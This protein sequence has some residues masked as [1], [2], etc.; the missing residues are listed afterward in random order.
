[1]V[2]VFFLYLISLLFLSYYILFSSFFIISLFSFILTIFAFIQFL[3]DS[4]NSYQ[5]PKE[6]PV[7]CTPTPSPLPPIEEEEF[8]EVDDINCG[9][10][11]LRMIGISCSPPLTRRRSMNRTSSIGDLLS[12]SVTIPLTELIPE[13]TNVSIKVE[14]DGNK[15]YI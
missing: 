10:V 13:S 11:Y 7:V 15:Y 12:T 4:F 1:M 5:Y 6:T 2:N 9:K 14:E 3:H 8:H